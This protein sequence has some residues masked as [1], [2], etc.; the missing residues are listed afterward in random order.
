MQPMYETASDGPYAWLNNILA[1]SVGK[2][3]ALGIT[4]DVYQIL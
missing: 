1:V 4:Y 2:Q 3:E